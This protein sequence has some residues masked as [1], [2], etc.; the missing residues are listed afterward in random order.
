M[1][2]DRQLVKWMHSFDEPESDH[3]FPVAED[4]RCEWNDK[5]DVIR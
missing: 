1:H 5:P 4:Y 2:S 3:D